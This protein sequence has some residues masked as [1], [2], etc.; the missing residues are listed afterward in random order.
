[1]SRETIGVDADDVIAAH[2]AAFAEFSN[3]YYGTNI[4][5]EEYDDEWT[6]IWGE[7]SYE[8]IERRA[9]EF[10]TPETTM[11]YARIEEASP[12]LEEL[13][14]DYR[15]AL[16]TARPKQIVPVT[17]E[18]LNIHFNGVFDEVHFVPIWEPT[19]TV[20]KADIC[21]QIGA[22]HLLDD[23]V[24]HCNPAVE[25]GINALLFGKQPRREEIDPRVIVVEDWAAVRNYFRGLRRA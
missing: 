11:A 9:G 4:T 10:H 19:N 14:E 8:E 23:A 13:H 6:N 17:H 18:W 22:T 3:T 5:A 1:M 12:V 2:A 20:T 21:R 24:R 16:V 25:V 15:L 7:L